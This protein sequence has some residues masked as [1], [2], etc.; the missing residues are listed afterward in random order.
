MGLQK[1]S[2][3]P[4][5]IIL[6]TI[7]SLFL[8]PSLVE[9]SDTQDPKSLDAFVLDRA[10]R[11]ITKPHTG[12][13]YNVSLPANFS[14]IEVSAI[15]VVTSSFW[16][17]GLNYSFL[18]FPPRIIPQPNVKR[19]AIVYK[20]MGNWSSHYFSV[21]NHTMVSPVLGF[22]AYVSSETTL[23]DTEKMMKMSLT[24]LGD[25]ITVRFPQTDPRGRDSQG[26]PIC[27]KFHENGSIEFSNMS[28]PYECVTQR[29]GH[30]SLVVPLASE[31][32]NDILHVRMKASSVWR[33]GGLV[34]AI[35]GLVIVVVLCVAGI[36]RLVKKKK[37][38]EM[39]K[40]S[41]KAEPFDTFWVGDSKMPAAQ[42][43]R[44]QAALENEDVP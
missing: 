17:R 2:Q 37:I 15:R 23:I 26:K 13:L 20:N 8:S 43:T 10:N 41:Q 19:M 28:R 21:P 25:P 9:S 36:V 39:E 5:L 34:L 24:I 7:V 12:T 44:T 1:F 18:H 30:Y 22:M 16:S 3:I 14:G 35:V 40:N 32:N 31:G 6:N 38:T 33:M 29:Q 42:M 27:A 4:S 11:E